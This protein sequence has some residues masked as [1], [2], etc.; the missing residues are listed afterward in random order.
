MR[1]DSASEQ[2]RV[3]FQRPVDAAEVLNAGED[4]DLLDRA[5]PQTVGDAARLLTTVNSNREDTRSGVAV[6]MVIA[7]AVAGASALLSR[8][9]AVV[10]VVIVTLALVPDAT[11]GMSIPRRVMSA[12]VLLSG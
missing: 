2:R 5:R 6:P 1:S 11:R 9:A 4:C 7:P 10:L 12:Q 8:G 3:H